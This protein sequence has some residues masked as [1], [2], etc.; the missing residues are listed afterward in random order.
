MSRITKLLV[1]LA[2]ALP[3]HA[4]A[5]DAPLDERTATYN[6]YRAAFDAGRFQD[7]LPLAV[8]VVEM[9]ASQYGSEA[10]ELANPLTN[11]ATTLYRM[12]QHGEALDNYRRALTVLDLAGNPTD[13]RLI[14]P[15]HGLGA[16]LRALDR[17]EEAIVPLKRAVDILRNRDGLYAASQ[18]PIL[19]TLVDSYERT[20]RRDEAQ[21]EHQYAFNVAEQAYGAEDP[22]MI[23]PLS[24]LAAWNE[25]VGR[26]TQARLPYVRAVQIA[27]REQPGGP[28]GVD[29][30]RGIARTYRLAF[31]HGESQDAMMASPA[32][33]PSSMTQAQLAAMANMPSGE[34]ERALRNAL[35]RLEGGGTA[36]AADRGQVLLELGD[37]YRLAGAGARAMN[38]WMQAWS[39]LSAAG[40]TSAMEDP[41]PVIYRPPSVAVSQ[42]PQDPQQYSIQEVQLRLSVAAD[43]AVRDV[44]VANPAKERE[45][46]E[47]AVSSAVR[48]GTWRPAFAGGVPVADGDYVF[49]EKVYVR[50]GEQGSQDG[51]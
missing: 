33:L 17:H 12:G 16:T 34:G 4:I 31:I 37:W 20:W 30:L 8:R 6:Q 46:A 38:S 14:P 11:L 25:K 48:R 39:E 19:R 49:T 10:A 50:I 42:R 2:C 36:R 45:G 23:G 28:K 5:A 18:L 32:E 13:R 1:A 3:L 47:R 35:Q 9:T 24:D 40:D 7:A 15:L 41:V 21:R 27:D 29:P 43:G 51:D 44:T 26:Y 22:R